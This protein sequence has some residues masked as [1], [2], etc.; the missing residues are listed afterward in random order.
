MSVKPKVVESLPEEIQATATKSFEKTV[1]TIKQSAAAATAGLEQA[2]AQV[3][4]GVD[5]A[6]K[7]AEQFAQFQ[8]GNFEAFVKSSQVLATG[9]QDIGKLMAST[10]QANFEEAVAT[11]RQLG[12]VKSVREAFELQTTYAKTTMEKALAESGKLTETSLKLAEQVA[13]PLTARV[14][15]AVETF[16]VRA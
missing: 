13:A 12:T 14:N 10:A 4:Q 7:T 8:Q 6:V 5:K 2:Q 16:S 11:F 3:K 15:A 9:L 1:E